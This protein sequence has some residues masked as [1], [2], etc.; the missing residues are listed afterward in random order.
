MNKTILIVDKNQTNIE[1]L[2]TFLSKNSFESL[3]ASDYESLDNIIHTKKAVHL[4]LMDIVGF[5]V[6]IWKYCQ[7]FNSIQIPILILSSVQ[8]PLMNKEIMKHGAKGVL[9][10]PVN[11]RDFLDLLISMT[12]EK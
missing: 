1:L 9:Q 5:D 12:D 4:V 6:T 11:L 7:H 3:A 10:K 8:N 2:K